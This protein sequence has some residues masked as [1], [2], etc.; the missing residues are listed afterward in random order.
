MQ[1]LLEIS[2]SSIISIIICCFYGMFMEGLL[3]FAIFIPLRSYLGGLHMKSYGNCFICSS[4]TLMGVLVLVKYFEQG[5]NTSWML[6]IISV[7]IVLWEAQKEKEL[8]V[9]GKYFYPIIL[10]ICIGVLIIAI[11]FSV[12][13]HNSLIFLMACTNMLVAVSKLLEPK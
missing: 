9:E 7:V 13:G 12:V 8:D 3:F 4:I 5:Y 1:M 2:C 11:V 6:L 10:G